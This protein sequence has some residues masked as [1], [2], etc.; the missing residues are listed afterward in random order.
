MFLPE[1]SEKG[2]TWYSVARRTRDTDYV[3]AFSK[4]WVKKE[5]TIS[6]PGPQGLNEGDSQENS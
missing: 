2:L 1:G 5:N 4:C 6:V 3:Q